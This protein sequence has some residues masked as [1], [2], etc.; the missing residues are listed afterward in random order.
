MSRASRRRP[1]RLSAYV[2]LEAPELAAVATLRAML[3]TTRAALLA[4]NPE[5]LHVP[6]RASCEPAAGQ[7]W[8]ANV[9][10]TQALALTAT[11]R[12]YHAAVEAR[13]AHDA[14]ALDARI[15]F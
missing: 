6:S 15:P 1:G 10:L 11:L 14:V 3:E 7:V 13:R 5:L 12:R 9:A 8:L 4:A 2:L